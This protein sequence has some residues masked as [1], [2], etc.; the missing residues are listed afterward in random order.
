M[1]L[2]IIEGN[3]NGSGAGEIDTWSITVSFTYNTP[4]TLASNVDLSKYKYLGIR[5]EITN[6]V[7]AYDYHKYQ[8]GD[9]QNH[10]IEHYRDETNKSSGNYT[11]YYSMFIPVENLNY[12]TNITITSTPITGSG[13]AGQ[14]TITLY[15]IK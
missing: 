6:N 5:E 10:G 4:V 15:A 12:I 14:G 8:I 9:N 11:T 2:C 7:Y 13:T 3:G 1:G